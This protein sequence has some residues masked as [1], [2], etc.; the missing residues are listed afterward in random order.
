[1]S[2]TD[3]MRAMIDQLMGTDAQSHDDSRQKY[4]FTDFTVCRSF[5]LGCCPYEVLASTVSSRSFIRLFSVG[6]RDFV[7]FV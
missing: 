1:M 4:H 7:G 3:Q 5:L 2:A 6:I